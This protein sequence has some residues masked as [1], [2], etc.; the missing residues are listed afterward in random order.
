MN[1]VST[2]TKKL[3]G[4]YKYLTPK[5]WKPIP[6]K[7]PYF[8]PMADS[9]QSFLNSMRFLRQHR[10]NFRVAKYKNVYLNKS[11][12]MGIGQLLQNCRY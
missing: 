12:N 8:W 9:L 1:P 5:I 6:N 11:V 2:K 7:H 10:K 4:I 3:T